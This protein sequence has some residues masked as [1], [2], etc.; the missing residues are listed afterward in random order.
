ML[1]ILYVPPVA[2]VLAYDQ[3]WTTF[4]V[5][6][7]DGVPRSKTRA[8]SEEPTTPYRHSSHSEIPVTKS[9]ARM[10]TRPW[11]VIEAGVMEPDGVQP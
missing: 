1:P 4:G 6:L 11:A 3:A 10:E 2:V 9:S 8:P 5:A 7:G